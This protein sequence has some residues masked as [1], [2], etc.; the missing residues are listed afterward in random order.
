MCALRRSAE[1]RKVR[2]R[3]F[4]FHKR[5]GNSMPVNLQTLVRCQLMLT[6]IADPKLTPWLTLPMLLPARPPRR[7]VTKS[8]AA[9]LP[10]ADDSRDRPLMI[11][12]AESD[13]FV[14]GVTAVSNMNR[15]RNGRGHIYDACTAPTG[16][17]L[18]N[19]AGKIWLH[20]RLVYL[21]WYD[22]KPDGQI[23]HN[24]GDPSNNRP[25]NLEDVSSAENMRRSQLNPD[26]GYG[27]AR[28]SRP[29]AGSSDGGTTW[30]KFPSLAAAAGELGFHAS[31]ISTICSTSRGSTGG[32][33]F[34]YTIQ[35]DL[36]GEEWR[37]IQGI[38]VS[39]MGRLQTKTSGKYEPAPCT[40][41]Y[42]RV[43]A[44]GRLFMFHRLV[45]QAFRGDPI[46]GYEADHH[47]GNNRNN[48]L[49]NLF[50]L[51]P[52]ENK[53]KKKH[54]A[55]KADRRQVT[56]T[57]STGTCV[58]DSVARAAEAA[59]LT[60]WKIY[61][62]CDSGKPSHGRIFAYVTVMPQGE[63]F[64]NVTSDDLIKLGRQAGRAHI[65]MKAK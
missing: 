23:D 35:P 64:K 15:V 10:K 16:Y 55:Q 25:D 24:D 2:H 17:R 6:M 57:S 21:K 51:S 59:D 18:V 13:P 60:V 29:I 54:A 42:C 41:G 8:P 65:N 12:W 33:T 37:P 39:N 31:K 43:G 22:R 63:I 36:P 1:A 3:Y 61:E 26:R 58:Y 46:A 32:W 28:L 62:L 48:L 40:D 50:W 52:A 27:G 4:F 5:P 56:I 9:E 44:N 53:A 7:R 19:I 11:P 20:H 47:D 34:S 38:S 14:K 49:D 45:C 30:I